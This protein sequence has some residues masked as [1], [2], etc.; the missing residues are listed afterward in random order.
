MVGRPFLSGRQ[1]QT[2]AEEAKT[3]VDEARAS[4]TSSLD[5]STVAQQQQQTA[6]TA[7]TPPPRLICTAD[8]SMERLGLALC[9][10]R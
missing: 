1:I 6:T 9:A 7:T 4:R 10:T 5:P 2:V 8:A 3:K